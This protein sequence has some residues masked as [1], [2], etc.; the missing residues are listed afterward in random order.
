M[1]ATRR[2]TRTI[3]RCRTPSDRRVRG[4]TIA[5]LAEGAFLRGVPAPWPYN[6]VKGA[7]VQEFQTRHGEGRKTSECR[8]CPRGDLGNE[9][10]LGAGA[11]TGAQE[12][13]ASA[14]GATGLADEDQGGGARPAPET[15]RVSRRDGPADQGRRHA[16]TRAVA[17]RHAGSG[18]WRFLRNGGPF[19]RTWR[20]VLQALRTGEIAVR[21][22][23][24]GEDAARRHA[25]WLHADAG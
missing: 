14:Q 18:P 23:K 1:A 7:H 15:A 11:K 19:Q 16:R 20:A 22:R 10:T 12:T 3:R 21:S 17:A 25:A 2:V 6:R 8:Q 24:Q 4:G 13:R 5:P 9:E